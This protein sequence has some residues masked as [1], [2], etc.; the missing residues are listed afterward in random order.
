VTPEVR[1]L[2]EFAIDEIRRQTDVLEECHMNPDSKLVEP[3]EVAEE[4]E[5]NR[6][7]VRKAE[8]AIK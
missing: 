7:W 4:I 6:A 8:A 1:L 2:L 3:T 5:A